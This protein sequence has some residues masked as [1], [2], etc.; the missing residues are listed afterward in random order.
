[1]DSHTHTRTRARARYRTALSESCAPPTTRP[2]APPWL[3]PPTSSLPLVAASRASLALTEAILRA[4]TGSSGPSPRS[5]NNVSRLR[6]IFESLYASAESSSRVSFF[7]GP[8]CPGIPLYRSTGHLLVRVVHTPVFLLSPPF[9]F[10]LPRT[11]GL[12]KSVE[13]EGCSGYGCD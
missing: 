10:P 11:T 1:M 2:S 4:S 9:S 3:I 6:A 5:T 12:W 13:K 7:F 8:L